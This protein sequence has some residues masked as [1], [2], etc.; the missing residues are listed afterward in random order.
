MNTSLP[1]TQKPKPLFKG[2]RVAIISPSAPSSS[3][4]LQAGVEWLKTVGFEPILMPYAGSKWGYMA[5]QDHERLSDLIVAVEDPSID[6]ILCARG[7]Y[8]AGR[9]LDAL[10]WQKW[11]EQSLP[12]K[13]LMGFSDIT[14]LHEAF[15]S[16]LGWVTFYSPMLTSN[17]IKPEADW[18]RQEW[19][20]FMQNAPE[21]QTP[22][23]FENLDAYTCL[24]AG[25]ATG[26]LAGG[27]L[28]LIAAMCGTPWQPNY[29]GALLVIEDWKESYYTLDRQFTQLHQA[30]IFEGIAGLILADFSQ[31][32]SEPIHD[33][34]TQLGW[35]CENLKVPMGFGMTIGHGAQTLTIPL[36]VEAR[37]S[38][39][40]GSLTLLASPFR[41]L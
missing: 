15:S 14:L 34:P 18:T 10:P 25:S 9:L 26:R 5:A 8:G 40:E 36:G 22:Y 19:L 27:N 21:T 11:Q 39:E 28:S 24:Q 2:A 23:T 31:I 37:F 35:L 12:C 7:G 33:L 32:A 3:E 1:K 41:P 30:G 20:R 4:D 38:A 6:A 13:A 29:T 16:R 17:L